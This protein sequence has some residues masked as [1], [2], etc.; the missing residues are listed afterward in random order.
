MAD[1][2]NG[3][4][5]D[6]TGATGER[7]TPLGWKVVLCSRGDTTS[8]TISLLEKLLS[9]GTYA[10]GAIRTNRK[11]FPSEISEEARRLL[12]GESVFRQCGNIVATA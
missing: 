12:R 6:Y 5:Y 11:N 10:C 4:L 2:L 7:E 1:A 3:Y 9:Q 8:C